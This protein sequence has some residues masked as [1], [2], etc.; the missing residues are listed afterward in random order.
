MASH[1]C[2]LKAARLVGNYRMKETLEPITVTVAQV[3]ELTGLSIS[4][5]YR[6]FDSGKLPRKKLGGKTLVLMSDLRSYLDT[7]LKAA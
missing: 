1:A 3:R 2:V 7:E 4:S 6:L 5:I